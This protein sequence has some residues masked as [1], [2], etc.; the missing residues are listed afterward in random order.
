MTTP[1]KRAVK[2]GK[3][4]RRKLARI[5]LAVEEIENALLELRKFKP[6]WWCG[7]LNDC[8]ADLYYLE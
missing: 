1:T 4:R 7:I 2:A 8:F 6:E 3:Q 5:R